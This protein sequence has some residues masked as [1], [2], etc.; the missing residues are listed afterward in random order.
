MIEKEALKIE[1][2]ARMINRKKLLACVSPMALFLSL[3]ALNGLLKSHGGNF[4]LRSAEYWIY[5]AQT[6]LC[7]VLLIWFWREY[8]LARP[9]GPGFGILIGILACVLWVAPQVFFAFPAR[10]KGFNPDVFATQPVLYGATVSLRFLRLVVV[11]PLL[12]EIFWRGFLLR[13]LINEDFEQV[14]IGTFTWLSFIVVA[15][16]FGFSHNQP[17]WGAAILTGMLYNLVAYRTKSLSTCVLTHAVT[18][19]LLGVWIV[20]TG[21][22]GFW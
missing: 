16:A 4:W 19:L 20:K 17:D 1:S 2:N 22:W 13:F 6:I 3:L 12:E 18:N 21:Q 5:P 10:S 9:S 15:L 7:G 14:P 11:V 8:P